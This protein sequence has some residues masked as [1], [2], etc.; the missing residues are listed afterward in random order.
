M[1]SPGAFPRPNETMKL[2]K[3]DKKIFSAGRTAG[4]AAEKKR[5]A[6][7]ATIENGAEVLAAW[8]GQKFLAN[9]GTPYMESIPLHYT[10]GGVLVGLSMWGRSTETKELL[11]SA[12]VGLIAGQLAVEGYKNQGTLP[13]Q[14]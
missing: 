6:S 11:G 7:R 3:Q 1:A 12:G 10:L 13:G 14:G 2:S 5:S 9:R 4:R 8:G